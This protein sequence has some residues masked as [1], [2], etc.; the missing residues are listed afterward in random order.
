[1]QKG[2]AFYSEKSSM[3]YLILIMLIIVCDQLTKYLTRAVLV[4][5]E[6]IAVI[7]DFFKIEY[8]INK[9]AAFGILSGEH[10]LLVV[11]PIIL[12]IVAI[13]LLFTK[14]IIGRPAKVALTMIMGGGISNVIDRV[15][16]GQVTDMLSFKIFPPVFNIADTM[17]V[18]GAGILILYVL[19][20]GSESGSTRRKSA[21]R[22]S[23]R[24]GGSR[25]KKAGRRKSNTS[26]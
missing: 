2:T 1:L 24:S 21:S 16:M 17:V 9:G 5:G 25:Q 14:K 11:I 19:F 8:V 15:V 3:P 23:V 18:I 7:G 4:P 12:I 13:C 10:R 26:S 22:A 6:S 20:G